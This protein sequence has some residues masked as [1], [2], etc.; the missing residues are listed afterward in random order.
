MKDQYDQI[1]QS[2]AIGDVA[3]EYRG[4]VSTP[5]FNLWRRFASQPAALAQNGKHIGRTE[6]V[7]GLYRRVGLIRG[8]HGNRRLA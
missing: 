2:C 7:F 3:T 8:K 5:G 1:S 4:S 6:W